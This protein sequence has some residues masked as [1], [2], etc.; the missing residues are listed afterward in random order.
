MDYASKINAEYEAIKRN[1]LSRTGENE[2]LTKTPSVVK[3]TRKLDTVIDS[4]LASIIPPLNQ[5]STLASS[6]YDNLDHSESDLL[7][8]K[9]F[10]PSTVYE[11]E[12]AKDESE[13]DSVMNR[14]NTSEMLN[15]IIQQVMIAEDQ[16][17][18]LN[19]FDND[20]FTW[21]SLVLG[22]SSKLNSDDEKLSISKGIIWVTSA[23]VCLIL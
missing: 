16:T 23:F 11:F 18:Q 2:I 9:K 5:S 4:Q 21:H 12:E 10:Q 13:D 3:S 14:S 22:T 8:A 15:D 19:K 1:I 6:F 7:D 17:E 20:D